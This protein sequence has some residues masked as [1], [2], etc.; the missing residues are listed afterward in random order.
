MRTVRLP[1]GEQVSALGQG[2]WYLGDDRF[3]RRAEIA[4]LQ[5]G[6]DLGLI[7]SAEMYGEGRAESLL[8]EALAGRRDAAFIVSKVYPHNASRR[9]GP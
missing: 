5:L 7:D 6:L 8:G 3:A 4:A 1:S 2:T 9:G